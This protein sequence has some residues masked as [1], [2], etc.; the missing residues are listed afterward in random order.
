MKE[1]TVEAMED[2]WMRCLIQHNGPP[3]AIVSNRPP[4]F[5]FLMWKRICSLMKITRKLSTA[6]HPEPVHPRMQ[7][8]PWVILFII[9]P[10]RKSMLSHDVNGRLLIYPS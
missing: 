7:H 8:I 4:Q 1:M 5:G 6:L 10:V 9:F 3:S 2:A